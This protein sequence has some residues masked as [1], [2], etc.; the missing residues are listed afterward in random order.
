[1]R[2]R[3]PL[4]SPVQDVGTPGSVRGALGN[5]RPYRD[6]FEKKIY[7]EGMWS[8]L[9]DLFRHIIIDGDRIRIGPGFDSGW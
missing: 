3:V 6:A 8:E 5:W 1:M 4:K 7:Q 2:K 9:D